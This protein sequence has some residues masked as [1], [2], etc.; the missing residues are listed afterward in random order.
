MVSGLFDQE[1]SLF[2]GYVSGFSPRGQS[3]SGYDSKDRSPERSVWDGRDRS[4]VCGL[5]LGFG[6]GAGLWNITT[7]TV[8]RLGMTWIWYTDRPLGDNLESTNGLLQDFLGVS[9]LSQEQQTW[10]WIVPGLFCI[11]RYL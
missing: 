10:L 4:L 3:V 5:R 11:G 2:S 6:V 7:G 8:G 9:G 1:R